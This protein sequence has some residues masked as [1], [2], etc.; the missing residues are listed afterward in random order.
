MSSSGTKVGNVISMFLYYAAC[1][2]HVDLRNISANLPFLIIF[3]L[4]LAF[5][6]LLLSHKFNILTVEKIYF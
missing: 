6:L 5:L 1:K 4:Y 3:P 2:C